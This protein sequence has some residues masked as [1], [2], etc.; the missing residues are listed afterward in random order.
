MKNYFI[1]FYMGYNGKGTTYGH[2]S[3]ELNSVFP[4]QKEIIK[5][6]K[7][8]FDVIDLVPTNILKVSE[9]EYFEWIRK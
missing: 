1:I 6:I 4:N 3:I 9:V 5:Y 7:D 8:N 2:C